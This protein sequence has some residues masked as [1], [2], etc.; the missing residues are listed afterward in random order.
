MIKIG[1]KVVR[2]LEKFTVLEGTRDD[3]GHDVILS[4]DMV[5]DHARAPRLVHPEAEKA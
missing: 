3:I 2:D 1:H 4:G 5:R